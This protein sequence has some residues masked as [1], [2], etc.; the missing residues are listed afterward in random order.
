MLLLTLLP[1]ASWAEVKVSAGDYSITLD[2]A[3]Y[4]ALTDADA[5]VAAPVIGTITKSTA[6]VNFTPIGV[7]KANGDPVEGNIKA[8]GEYYI[9]ANLGEEA[10]LL[11]VPFYVA[12]PAISGFDIVWNEGTWNTSSNTE[13]KGLYLYHNYFESLDTPLYYDYGWWHVGWTTAAATAEGAMFTKMF[14]QQVPSGEWGGR[15]ERSWISAINSI[16]VAWPE[17]TS[18]DDATKL[19]SASEDGDASAY[20]ALSAE[21]GM[22]STNW[23]KYGY[24]WFVF[25]APLTDNQTALKPAFIYNDGTNT[26]YDAVSVAYG[27]NSG[28]S[29]LTV[30][31][32]FPDAGYPLTLPVNNK[33]GEVT[34]NSYAAK[35]EKV[36][37]LLIPAEVS[38]AASIDGAKLVEVQVTPVSGVEIQYQTPVDQLVVTKEM[39]SITVNPADVNPFLTDEGREEVA[40]LLKIDNA[41]QLSKAQVGEY[42]YRFAI[43]DPDNYII[44]KGDVTYY[45]KPVLY[46]KVNIVAGENEL[47]NFGTEQDPTYAFAPITGIP[48]DGKAHD[49]VEGNY[50]NF[51]TWSAETGGWQYAHGTARFVKY[52]EDADDEGTHVAIVQVLTN[53]ADGAT[54]ANDAAYF[55]GK[56]YGIVVE[57]RTTIP[58]GRVKLIP[59]DWE[60]EVVG[61]APMFGQVEDDEAIWA[62]ISEKWA[63]YA[64]PDDLGVQFYGISKTDYA[65]LLDVPENPA[66]YQVPAA[67]WSTSIPQGKDI[68]EYY[69]Y[70]KPAAGADNYKGGD[71]VFIG[72]ASIVKGG[73]PTFAGSITVGSEYYTYSGTPKYNGLHKKITPTR[74]NVT[75]NGETVQ[76]AEI[77]YYV[78]WGTK[79]EQGDIVWNDFN[80]GIYTTLDEFEFTDE[81]N[82]GHEGNT[83]YRLVAKFLGNDKYSETWTSQSTVKSNA[84]DILKPVVTLTTTSKI[85]TIPYGVEPADD[86]F[87]YTVGNYPDDFTAAEVGLVEPTTAEYTWVA[88]ETGSPVGEY[89]VT[90][91]KEGFSVNSGF[92]IK[93]VPATIKVL[94]GDVFAD[95]EDQTLVFGETLPLTLTYVQGYLAPSETEAIEN[96]NKQV[97]RDGTL[98]A[99]MIKDAEG[100][101][102]ENEVVIPLYAASY[103]TGGNNPVTNWVTTVLPVGIWE[104]TAD[105]GNQDNAAYKFAVSKGTWTVTP[106]D[107][108]DGVRGTRSFNPHKTYTSEAI[109][110]DEFDFYGSDIRYRDIDDKPSQ[111]SRQGRFNPNRNLSDAAWNSLFFGNLNPYFEPEADEVNPAHPDF[112]IVGYKDNINAG[113]A[114]VTIEGITNFKG[115]RDLTFTIDKARLLVYPAIP[116]GGNKWKLGTSEEGKYNYDAQ[117]AGISIP[118]ADYDPDEDGPGRYFEDEN[119]NEFMI[120]YEGGIKTQLSHYFPG[121]KNLDLTTTKGFKDLAVQRIVPAT[122]GEYEAGIRAYQK[123]DEATGKVVEADNYTFDFLTAP[124]TIEKGDIK[125]TVAKA[126]VTYDGTNKPEYTKDFELANADELIPALAENWK[127]VVE[128]NKANVKF[129]D[130]WEKDGNNRFNAGN[131]TITAA[132]VEG[133]TWADVFSATNYNVT[134]VTPN[135]TTLTVKPREITLTA[136]SQTFNMAD[137]MG[138]NGFDREQLDADIDL[139]ARTPRYGLNGEL[140]GYTV[141]YNSAEV[142]EGTLGTGD[143]KNDVIE[144]IN[145]NT[146]ENTITI[147]TTSNANYKQPIPTVDGVLTIVPLDDDD[148]ELEL[149]SVM[150]DQVEYVTDAWGS[151]VTDPKTGKPVVKEGSL[152]KG[153]MHKLSDYDGVTIRNI[154]LTLKAPK[155]MQGETENEAFS[156]WNK[157]EWHAMVLPFAVT[158]QDLSS[159]FGDTY[160]I[161]NVVDAENTTEGDVKF[162][163]PVEIDQ[164]IPANTPFC[165]KVAQDFDYEDALEFER[166]DKFAPFTIV[167]PAADIVVAK[168]FENEWGYTF[169]GTYKQELVVSSET[170]DLRFLGPTKWYF[171]KPEST[172]TK[173]YMQPYTGYVNLGAG[174]ATREVTFTF[175]EED[176]STTAIKAVD[177]MNGNKANAEG[178]Y[179]VDG[180]KLNTAPTQKGVY[181]QNGKKV[182]K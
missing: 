99:T 104:V 63:T 53:T 94:A 142:S 84:F 15:F 182:L 168:D 103:T 146:S 48:Y 75:V 158:A 144:A 68:D 21:G 120:T 166:S 165:V 117:G 118:Y 119:G 160:V 138:E 149:L 83:V 56:F 109:E 131:Y 150:A 3:Q 31:G 162:M 49:L 170:P 93:V 152:V 107:I 54:T 89:E 175:E 78:E 153:D 167:N 173:Y 82:D 9:S 76:D 18:N 26:Y 24:P 13:G 161:V 62:E 8:V 115:T 155:L 180:I 61:E 67:N 43:A 134:F 128:T 85:A 100:N 122:V 116:E 32:L 172:T 30:S 159:A 108:T 145:V 2:K 126:E 70:A 171:V 40:A 135:T 127:S 46:S 156:V 51:T 148:A 151:V 91:N 121:D 179:R 34:D 4:V 77:R 154:S 114:T 136:T 65:K 25:Y 157:N 41:E 163:L 28:H 101:D 113:T 45:I 19:K 132:P 36:Q 17:R 169:E 69:I 44:V 22:P 87:G 90:V 102:V 177:F 124:L 88:K 141:N 129:S 52:V 58:T 71:P 106:R 23:K 81:E 60:T 10:K 79:P 92:E 74:N 20:A 133:K 29:F 178:L 140:L 5:G 96:F 80:D 98:K 86:N 130:N 105:F 139:I 95:I 50:Y 110:L 16:D 11:K 38:F 55:V 112:K 181:I 14:D 73:E 123:K 174:S 33:T 42:D 72:T 66:E 7:F 27:G 147:T 59:V 39:V 97:Y 12:E 143:E 137:Y 57:N 164:E 6:S 37:V 64:G 35:L 47:I 176:G 125:V 111:L 1:L